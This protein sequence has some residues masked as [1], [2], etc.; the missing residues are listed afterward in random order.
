M[1]Y[2]EVYNM[3]VSPENNIGKTVKMSGAYPELGADICV[4]GVYDTYKEGGYTY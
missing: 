3:M 2:A 4:I 1:V